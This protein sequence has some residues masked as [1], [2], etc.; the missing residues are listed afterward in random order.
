[1]YSPPCDIYSFF[2]HGLA[3]LRES[4]FQ[5]NKAILSTV[6]RPIDFPEKKTKHHFTPWVS[7]D[8]EFHEDICCAS[9]ELV[10]N[11]LR[12][13]EQAERQIVGWQTWGLWLEYCWRYREER[14]MG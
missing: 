4:Q 1:M 7:S 13:L 11:S 9:I 12:L 10:V 6:L 3:R 5:L 2:D 8:V 14:L